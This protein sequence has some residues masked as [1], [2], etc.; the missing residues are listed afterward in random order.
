VIRNGIGIDTMCLLSTQEDQFKDLYAELKEEWV[1]AIQTNFTPRYT[2]KQLSIL[3]GCKS[4]VVFINPEVV[5]YLVDLGYPAEKITFFSDDELKQEIF[6]QGINCTI[7]PLNKEN[8]MKYKKH[9]DGGSINPAFG[10]S[11]EMRKIAESM[12]KGKLLVVTPNRDLEDRKY[13]ENIEYYKNLS[14]TAF[15]EAIYTSLLVVDTENKPETI[16]VESTDGR[17]STV[18]TDMTCIPQNDIENWIFA[19][20]VFSLKLPGYSNT[21][22]SQGVYYPD[23]NKVDVGAKVIFKVGRPDKPDEFLLTKTID[24]EDPSISKVKGFG[25][26]KMVVSRMAN[27]YK[28]TVA[29]YAGPDWGTSHNVVAIN[30]ESKEEALKAIDYYNSDKVLKLIKGFASRKSNNNQFFASIPNHMYSDKWDETL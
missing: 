13:L 9:F 14:N 5:N 15:D 24:S 26:H 29:K 1:T 20:K 2:I 21:Y 18:V 8:I 4:V 11:R 19:E 17:E 16:T 28:R 6:L 25:Y 10:I 3:L 12:V 7:L 22:I 23:F 27:P 30:F